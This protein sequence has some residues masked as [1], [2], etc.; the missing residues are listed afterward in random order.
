MRARHVAQAG[1]EKL[2]DPDAAVWRRVRPH[3]LRLVGTPLGLQPTEAIRV[4]W[5]R[6][7]IGAVDGVAVS[8]LHDGE[9]LAFRLSWSDPSADQEISDTTSFPDAAAVVLPA[10]PGAP[11][12]TMGAPGAPVNVWYWRADDEAGRARHL[13]AEGIGTSRTLDRELVRARGVWKEGG[14]R[15]VIARP[16]AVRTSEPVAQLTAGAR[17]LFAVAVWEGSRGERAGLKAF[18]GDWQGLELDGVPEARR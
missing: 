3:S 5:A 18:S 4:S 8:V 6:R 15:V 10:V 13:L 7:P 14:W 12:V 2:L 17:T 9:T 1:M 16:L 11:L